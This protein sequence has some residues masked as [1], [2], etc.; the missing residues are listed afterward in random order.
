MKHNH[1]LEL[2]SLFSGK[3]SSKLHVGQTIQLLWIRMAMFTRKFTVDYC[4]KV[5]Y[6]PFI[7]LVHKQLIVVV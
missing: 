4:G 1:A 6:L 2:W 3:L 7:I 5:L